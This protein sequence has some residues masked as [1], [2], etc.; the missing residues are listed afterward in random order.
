M[1]GNPNGRPGAD[2]ES[3]LYI[4]VKR[5]LEARG[6]EVKGEVRDCD[7]VARRGNEPPIIVELKRQFTLALVLQGIDRLALTERVYLA[8]P[9]ASRSARGANPEGSS[10]R[11]LCRR[12]GLGLIV[13]GPA[14][15]RVVEEPGPY[16]PRISRPRTERLIDEFE[17]RHGD[18]NL[19]GS[20]RKPIVTAYRQD[21]L[22]VAGALVAGPQRIAELRATTGVARAATIL[23]RNIYGWFARLG[24][25]TYG[26]SA[27]GQAAIAQF[28]DA[29]AA[30]SPQAAA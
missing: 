8:V 2:S 5:F 4:P 30:I 29:L 26:L 6:F 12:L 11:R 13:L 17:R 7:I 10:V 20:S 22:R 24:R 28:S 18:P 23:Q 1:H 21:A 19:G 27:L 3:A 16:R 14:S 15:I 25:G 9:R